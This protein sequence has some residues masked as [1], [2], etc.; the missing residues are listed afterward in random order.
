[1]NKHL[2][3]AIRLISLI[4]SDVITFNFNN[5]DNVLYTQM[6]IMKCR[7]SIYDFVKSVVEIST[8]IVTVDGQNYELRMA[9]SSTK[10]I[11]QQYKI[12]ISSSYETFKIEC[13]DTNSNT[14]KLIINKDERNS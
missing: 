5:G 4:F 14:W 12:T 3:Y 2:E 11:G 13:F 9:N 1:M 10:N 8:F 6:S 7:T